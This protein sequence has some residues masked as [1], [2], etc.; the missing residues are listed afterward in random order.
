MTGALE[1][2]RAAYDD[3]T[4]EARARKT[5]GQTVVGYFLNSVPEELILAAGHFPVRLAGDPDRPTPLAD[6]YMEAYF[7]GEVRAL[8]QALV[9]G[10]F[11]FADLIVIPRNS[12]VYLQLYYLL[13]EIPRWEPEAAIPPLHLFDLLQSP[14]RTTETYVTGRMHALARRLEAIGGHTIS[15]TRLADAILATNRT[16][17]GLI[18]T[19]R[20]WQGAAPALD[21][22]DALKVIGAAS[23]MA[24]D[25]YDA[26]LRSLIKETPSAGSNGRP[27]VLIK[28]SPQSDPR[29]TALVESAGGA[30]V[31]HDHLWGDRTYDR[32]IEESGDRWEALAQHYIDHIPSPR[33]YPQARENRR[34]LALAQLAAADAVIIYHDEWDDTLGW[35]YPD[36]KAL[37]DDA[38][39]PSLFLKRQRWFDPP[40]ATQLAAVTAF[41]AQIERK[42]A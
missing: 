38:G 9:A 27:R 10:D 11:A 2:L 17:R 3:R 8:F 28:G 32:L 25:D 7:D 12:E 18:D 22:T 29:F 42:P 20:L 30:V 24:R 26:A 39:I 5:A 19:R 34:M 41:L 1:R 21:G 33:A 6:R 35:E 36:Q 15:D 23:A 13:R 40:Q 31:A 37:L 16:R 4:A 14:Y